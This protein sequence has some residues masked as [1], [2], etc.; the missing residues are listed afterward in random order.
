VE[1][2]RHLGRDV[3]GYARIETRERWFDDLPA[4]DLTEVSGLGGIRWRALRNLEV[5]LGGGYGQINFHS[6]QTTPGAVGILQLKGELEG[7]WR[8]NAGVTR[9]LTSDISGFN[10]AETVGHVGIEKQLGPRTRATIDAFGGQ[11][12]NQAPGIGNQKY[13]A[14][15]A[16]L[17]R[18]LTRTLQAGLVFRHWQTEGQG[19]LNDVTQN[20]VLLEFKYRR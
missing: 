2:E 16:A 12:D 13:Y 20:R 15:E 11:F 6:G 14:V 19:D 8:W 1:L 5:E 10:Y 4:D 3:I 9:M 17:R 18:Q 7:G